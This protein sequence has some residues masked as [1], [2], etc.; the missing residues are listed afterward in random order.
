[1]THLN[2]IPQYLVL[3]F[4]RHLSIKSQSSYNHQVYLI[5]LLQGANASV[6]SE[7]EIKNNII[8]KQF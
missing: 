2:N 1:M 5:N 6:Y 8:T 7:T 4:I 3:E